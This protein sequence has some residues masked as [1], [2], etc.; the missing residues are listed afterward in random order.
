METLQAYYDNLGCI[1]IKSVKLVHETVEKFGVMNEKPTDAVNVSIYHDYIHTPVRMEAESIK[2]AIKKGNYIE[3]LCWVN[4]L[5]GFYG[6]TLMS[7]KTRKGLTKERI[8]EII[9]KNDFN[10]KG[11][12]LL[13][14]K[15]CL[16]NIIYKP[17][18]STFVIT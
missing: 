18:Y 5:N 8:I 1:K 6:D 11:A 10:K 9:G 7:E 12:Q 14:W 4:A 16:K 3:N 2:Q 17:E 15:K 13:T